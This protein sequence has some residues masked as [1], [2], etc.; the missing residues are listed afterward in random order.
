MKVVKAIWTN[1]P[2]WTENCPWLEFWVPLGGSEE[3]PADM[4]AFNVY[5]LAGSEPGISFWL[6][7]IFVN[8]QIGRAHV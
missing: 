6:K 7:F 8:E 1:G 2:V 4:A 5:A 3:M